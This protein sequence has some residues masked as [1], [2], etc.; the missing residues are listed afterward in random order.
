MYGVYDLWDKFRRYPITGAEFT[1]IFLLVLALGFVV[2]FNDQSPVFEVAHWSLNLIFSLVIVFIAMFLPAIVQKLVGL[3]MGFKVDIKIWY[4]G[5][6]IA[7]MALFVSGGIYGLWFLAA[8]GI[9]LHMMER[10]RLGYFRYGLG[11]WSIGWV[12]LFGSLTNFFLAIIFRIFNAFAPNPFFE[13]AILVNVLFA[14][15]TMLPIPPLNGLNVLRASRFFYFLAFA[16][17]ITG[18]ALMV[19]PGVPLILALVASVLFG[20]ISAMSLFIFYDKIP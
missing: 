4:I 20:L 12:S 15:C 18:G 1:G 13:K 3:Q 5:V 11:L 17:I 9:T 10:H 14:V 7:L 6:V 19:M 8:T 2:G 16:G